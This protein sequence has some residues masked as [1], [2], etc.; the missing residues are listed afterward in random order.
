MKNLLILLSFIV[1]FAGCNKAKQTV[2]INE[3]Q[4]TLTGSSQ[5]GIARAYYPNGVLKSYAELKDGVLHGKFEDYYDNG[6]VKVSFTH[7]NGVIEGPYKMYY[8]NGQIYESGTYKN[9]FH[10]GRTTKYNMNG[11]IHTEIDYR[12]EKMERFT[13]YF[14]N[15]PVTYQFKVKETF[16]PTQSSF[17]FSVVPQPRFARYFL[18]KEGK[19]FIIKDQPYL[20]SKVPGQKM[21]FIVKGIS[22]YGTPFM[23]T[24][25]VKN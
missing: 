4:Y 6:K 11:S 7:K 10:D 22:K 23:L 24:Q 18:K 17:T 1:L 9:G 2:T 13:E 20:M 12:N 15:K 21:E 8:K 16:L 14:D 5:N 3:Q 19:T 25:K